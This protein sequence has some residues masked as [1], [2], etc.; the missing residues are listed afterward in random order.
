METGD[1]RRPDGPL[2]S[3]ADFTLPKRRTTACLMYARG[4]NFG[5]ILRTR[6]IL[7]R[8]KLAVLDAFVVLA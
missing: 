2:G 7:R 8:L 3:C 6:P 1:K 5:G 4:L